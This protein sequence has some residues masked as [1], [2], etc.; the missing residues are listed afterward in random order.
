MTVTDLVAAW[1]AHVAAE[2]EQKDAHAAVQTMADDA[3][4]VHVPVATGGRGRAA[5]ERFY[6]D[7]FVPSWPDD[8]TIAPGSRTVG[9]DQVVDEL[10]VSGTHDRPMPF[11]LPGV[12]PTG[13]RFSLLLVAVVGFRDGLIASEHIYWDQASLLVQLGLLPD[14][15]SLP[16]LG[17]A[18]TRA[19]T[20]RTYALNELIER[21]PST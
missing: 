15:E 6:A 18:Q 20:D 16:V 17:V 3:V 9:D 13:R 10:L 11:W 8:T 2:F 5:I 19:Y 14:A 4:L 21:A 7:V 1:E 12:E